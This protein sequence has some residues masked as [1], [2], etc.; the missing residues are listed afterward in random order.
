[1]HEMTTTSSSRLTRP[2]NDRV[3]FGVCSGIA[4]RYG[5]GPVLVRA[6]FLLT[7]L[8]GGPG[9]LAYLVLFFVMPQDSAA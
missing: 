1:M 4:R 5:W 8:L 6:A 2:L 3:F 7:A 9:L